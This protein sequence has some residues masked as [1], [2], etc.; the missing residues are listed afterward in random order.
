MLPRPH[1]LTR[2]SDFR[3]A[4]KNGVRAGTRVL[5][6][7]AVDCS[8]DVERQGGPRFGLVVSK[9]VGNAVVRHHTSRRLRHLAMDAI[10]RETARP[11]CDYVLRALPGIDEATAEELSHHFSAALRKAHGK[12]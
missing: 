1:K 8:T 10:A 7:H 12:L 4:V 11:Q 3:R 6:V 2:S 9:A 5:V